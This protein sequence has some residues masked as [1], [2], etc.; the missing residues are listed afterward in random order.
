MLDPDFKFS[1]QSERRRNGMPPIGV[2]A[3]ALHSGESNRYRHRPQSYSAL[4]D[5]GQSPHLDGSWFAGTGGA[6]IFSGGMAVSVEKHNKP[7]R[8]F[9]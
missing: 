7:L 5:C 3:S 6:V 4:G 2:S 8:G 1:R 9:A